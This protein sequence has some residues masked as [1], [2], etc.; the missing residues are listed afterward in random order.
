M[1]RRDADECRNQVATNGAEFGQPSRERA[2][3]DVADPGT[4]FRSI[5]VSLQS[6]DALMAWL[7]PSSMSASS[8]SR[9]GD[10]TIELLG[11]LLVR[12]LLATVPLHDDHF[13]DLTATPTRS[14]NR[15]PSGSGKERAGGLTRSANKAIA[16]A[17]SVSVLQA[18]P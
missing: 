16:S 5:S 17:S 1:D 2:G 13:D 15:L 3:S 6:G 18:G 14:A 4:D 12:G 11:Q 7:M 8:F 10:M 9:K